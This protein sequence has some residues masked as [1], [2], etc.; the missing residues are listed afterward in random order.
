[1]SNGLASEY[2]CKLVRSVSEIHDYNTRSGDDIAVGRIKTIRAQTSLTYGGF[3]YFN[4]LPKEIRNAESIRIFK[5]KLR[6]YVK[7]SLE[8][9]EWK[10]M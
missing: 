7:N 4:E 8:L 9:E 6:E 1:M 5:R 2:L 3:Q 10:P